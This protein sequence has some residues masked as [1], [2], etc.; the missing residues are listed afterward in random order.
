MSE[1]GFSWGAGAAGKA[2]GFCFQRIRRTEAKR[3][4]A[5]PPNTTTIP[6]SRKPP[7]G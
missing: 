2:G 1:S 6:A 4:S 3:P 7:T 5:T